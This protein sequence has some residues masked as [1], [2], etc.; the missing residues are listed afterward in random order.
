MPN[1][2]ALNKEENAFKKA[3]EEAK[4][5]NKKVNNLNN[6]EPKQEEIDEGIVTSIPI[7]KASREKK[8]QMSLTLKPSQK[9]KLNAL[10]KSVGMSVSD[11]VGYWAD[12]SK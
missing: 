4:S 12:N 10:A 6:V 1:Y 7:P 9:K 2:D 11:L 8:E 3:K 5:N